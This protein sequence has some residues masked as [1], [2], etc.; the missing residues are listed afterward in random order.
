MYFI[1]SNST[2]LLWIDNKIGH[3]LIRRVLWDIADW[4]VTTMYYINDSVLE[5]HTQ[6]VHKIIPVK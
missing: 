2:Y 1:E 6:N 5:K 4:V 3:F